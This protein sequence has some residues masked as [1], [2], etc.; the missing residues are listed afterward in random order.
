MVRTEHQMDLLR[1]ILVFKVLVRFR[2]STGFNRLADFKVNM[3]INNTGFKGS[4]IGTLVGGKV[5]PNLR[6]WPWS[7]CSV[8]GRSLRRRRRRPRPRRTCCRRRRWSRGCRRRRWNSNRMVFVKNQD[9]WMG[10]GRFSSNWS[11]LQ[12][13]FYLYYGERSGPKFE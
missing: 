3:I 6:L 7:C 8:V 10:S 11:E 9:H 4:I 13:Y 5:K 12:S 2:S 1:W